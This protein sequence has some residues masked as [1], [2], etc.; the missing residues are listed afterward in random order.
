MLLIPFELASGFDSEGP[1]AFA[2]LNN[3]SK[4]LTIAGY[5]VQGLESACQ[6]VLTQRTIDAAVGTQLDMIG[7]LV[8][9]V[10]NGLDDDTYRRYCRAAVSA[11]RSDGSTENLLTVVRL[12]LAEPGTHLHLVQSATATITMRVEGVSLTSPLAETAYTFLA[13]SAAG[14]VRVLMDYGLS[15]PSTWFRFDSGPGFDQGHL[16]GRIEH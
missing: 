16:I 9:Q 4:L 14:G 8:N 10:R 11:N 12:I 2:Q 1:D 3:I 7:L 6:Q 13:R 5:S 15:P